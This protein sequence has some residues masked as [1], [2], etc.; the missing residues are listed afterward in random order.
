MDVSNKYKSLTY[1]KNHAL[2]ITRI[3]V[4]LF[5]IS[6]LVVSGASTWLFAT[7][8]R[9]CVRAERVLVQLVMVGLDFYYIPGL[10]LIGSALVHENAFRYPSSAPSV[11]DQ[12]LSSLFLNCCRFFEHYFVTAAGVVVPT[13]STVMGDRDGELEADCLGACTL[14]YCLVSI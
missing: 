7:A 10:G 2:M 5:M 6:S 1:L 11:D 4:F 3:P 13:C 8:P 9:W 14:V 12:G